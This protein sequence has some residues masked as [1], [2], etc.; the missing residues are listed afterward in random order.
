[1]LLCIEYPPCDA[2]CQVVENQRSHYRYCRPFGCF[3]LC[4][5]TGCPLFFSVDNR[6][7]SGE[8][9]LEETY[10]TTGA[11][12]RSAGPVA[13]ISAVSYLFL[14]IRDVCFSRNRIPCPLLIGQMAFSP[15][16][17]HATIGKDSWIC[18]MT[19]KADV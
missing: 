13:D 2:C 14:M 4:I 3:G 11:G 16:F 6:Y 17:L 19:C 8:G 12:G 5:R 18:F 15:A 7:R 10:G 9:S 1:M